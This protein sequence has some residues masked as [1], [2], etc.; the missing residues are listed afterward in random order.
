VFG[1]GLVT[2]WRVCI[3]VLIYEDECNPLSS[4]FTLSPFRLAYIQG[5]SIDM[6]KKAWFSISICNFKLPRTETSFILPWIGKTT[7]YIYTVPEGVI[8]IFAG[9]IVPNSSIT[10]WVDDV[11]KSLG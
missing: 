1:A 8:P 2:P 10:K 4:T 6:T 11:E 9:M 7:E 5:H 3:H